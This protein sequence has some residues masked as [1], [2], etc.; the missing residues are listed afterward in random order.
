MDATLLVEL[1]CEELPPKALKR[2]G[3]AFAEG[4][5]RG[6]AK[7]E[8]LGADSA[9]RA[10]ATPRRLAASID[11]VKSASAPRAVQVKLMPAAV[12]LDAA[13]RPTAALLKKL[14]AAGLSGT[15]VSKLQ[16][17]L[18][19][20][21]EML[22]ADAT[23]PATPLAQALQGAL[24]EAIAGLPIPKVMSYQLADG[25]TT[26]QFVRPAHGLVALHGGEVVGVT[27]L[28]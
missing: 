25:E 19:G 12:A 6:L 4:L 27:A 11:R 13:G 8:M 2:L 28:G 5:H 9:A 16:R 26:V 18:D 17:R 7:R 10:F 15:D 21:A 22:F 1:F 23:T 3:D 24:D 14:E 20:K